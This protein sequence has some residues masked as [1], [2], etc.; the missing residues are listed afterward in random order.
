MCTKGWP[1]ELCPCPGSISLPGEWGSPL[2][3]GVRIWW[4]KAVPS[5]PVHPHLGRP[6]TAHLLA[7]VGTRGVTVQR[8]GVTLERL[9][10]TSLE[11][12]LPCGAT[13]VSSSQGGQRE[14]GQVSPSCHL[15][16]T[17]PSIN[18]PVPRNRLSRD[19]RPTFRGSAPLIRGTA[20]CKWTR[21]FQCEGPVGRAALGRG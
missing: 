17:F 3:W 7:V 20:T 18:E 2:V 21:T 19:L 6:H 15:P 12:V 1:A 13:R 4:E 8:A 5:C 11:G 16:L 10:V 9:K 14:R